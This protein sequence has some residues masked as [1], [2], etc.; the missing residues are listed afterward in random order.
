MADVSNEEDVVG[1][2]ERIRDDFGTIDILVN[3]A[4]IVTTA[5]VHEMKSSMW[6]ELLAIH[7]NGTFMC[8]REALKIM[9]KNNYGRIINTASQLAYKGH[10]GLAHYTAAKGAIIS[11][12][13]SLSLEIGDKN[14]RVNC[15]APGA[16]DTRMLSELPEERIEE[17]RQT[18]PKGKIANIDEITPA[19]LFLASNDGNHFVGQT[20]SPNG[21]DLFL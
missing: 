18:I 8:T 14:I 2:I 5:L 1:M 21:G 17:I 9:Y 4:G 3:N 19:Y 13:R 20:I 6:N 16:T 12:T 10:D 11:F 7:L 15:V